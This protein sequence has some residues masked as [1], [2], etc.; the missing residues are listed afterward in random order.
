M[1]GSK[2]KKVEKQPEVA[3]TSIAAEDGPLTTSSGVSRNLILLP[4]F[5]CIGVAIL[6]EAYRIRLMAINDFGAVIHEF[7]PYFVSSAFS[8][9]DE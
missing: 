3:N 9:L 8:F 6:V 4:I 2:A 7:D 5:F 1:A